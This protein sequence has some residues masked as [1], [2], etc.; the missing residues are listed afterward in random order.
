MGEAL[1]IGDVR[2]VSGSPTDVESGLVGWLSFV[3]NETIR[4]DGVALRR[5][6]DGR[7]ALSFPA[8]VDRAGKE[9]K[10]IRPLN[11]I[12]RRDIEHEVFEALGFPQG[13]PRPPAT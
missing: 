12:V 2:F 3:L 8:R 5:T 4:I 11:E 6:A 1:Q 9:W 7:P 13:Y 10:Y